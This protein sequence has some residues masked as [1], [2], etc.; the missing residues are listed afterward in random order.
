MNISGW[1]TLSFHAVHYLIFNDEIYNIRKLTPVPVVVSREWLLESTCGALSW[2]VYGRFDIW[3]PEPTFWR[4]GDEMRWTRKIDWLFNASPINLNFPFTRFNDV[5]GLLNYC[6]L[7]TSLSW[8]CISMSCTA[9]F[10]VRKSFKFSLSSA[11]IRS[12]GKPI[13]RR[14]G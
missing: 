3:M 7:L 8:C 2:S 14:S 9:I 4:F 1:L 10:G 12:K 11:R 6:R 13:A 5:T